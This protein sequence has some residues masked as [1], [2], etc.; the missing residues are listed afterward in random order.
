MIINP[1]N[2]AIVAQEINDAF[3]GDTTL[4]NAAN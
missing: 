1:K 2:R 4:T 3:I